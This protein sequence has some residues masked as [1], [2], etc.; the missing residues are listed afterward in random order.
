MSH[1]VDHCATSRLAI[2]GGIPR[3]QNP[4]YV[5]TPNLPRRQ[6]L[7]DRI[8]QVFE[9]NWLSNFGPFHYEFSSEICRQTAVKNAIPVA[10]ATIGLELAIR[11]L[12]LS[13]EV[14]VPA[15]TFVATAHA[16]RW[17]GITP[18]FCDVDP[19]THC[20]DPKKIEALITERTTG[21][22]GVHLW[23]SPCDVVAIER[24]AS[25]YQLKVIYDAAHAFGVKLGNTPIG[26][27]GDI[28]VFSFHATKLVNSLEGGAVVTNSKRLAECV[29]LMSNFGFTGYDQVE[30]IGTNGKLN[31]VSAAVGL[32]SL[33][34]I[35]HIID[36]NKRNYQSYAAAL[37]GIP[38]LTIYEYHP[39]VSPNYQYIVVDVDSDAFGFSRDQ[40]LSILHAENIFAR[41]YFFPGCHRMAPYKDE[42]SQV[43][44]VPVTESLCQRLICLPTGNQMDSTKIRQLAE[45]LAI[46]HHRN[47][48]LTAK[49]PEYAAQILTVYGQQKFKN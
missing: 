42:T 29:T 8:E 15:F 40:L 35:D 9:R 22:I 48:T 38:G 34:E 1:S 7:M 46:A 16:L 45:L 12:D 4:L 2:E 27:F 3:F 33:E 19:V 39:S 26:G 21:I 13:G 30:L 47:E 10:N 28:E 20:I 6:V 31:E 23:G 11:A 32:T 49:V 41:R 24:I 5:G 43:I 17:Q 18:V 25:T 37:D 14:I 36:V 44:D